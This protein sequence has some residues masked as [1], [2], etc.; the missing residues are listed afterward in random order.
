MRARLRVVGTV[1]GQAEHDGEPWLV[2]EYVPAPN[3]ADLAAGGLAPRRVAGI[4]A[5]VAEALA[6]AHGAGV[7]HRDVTPRNILVGA[8]DH[9]TLTDFG[10]SKIEGEDTLGTGGLPFAGVAAYVAPEVANGVKGG[11]KADVFS[12]GATLHAAVEGRSPW[13]DGDLV[14]TLAAAMKGGAVGGGAGAGA[15][16]GVVAGGDRGSARRDRRCLV[17]RGP[18]LGSR[19]SAAHRGDRAGRPDRAG[20]DGPAAGSGVPGALGRLSERPSCSSGWK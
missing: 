15:A 11:S 17:R 9:V 2:M 6:Y 12:L 5:Q 14:Q 20:G 4:G 10:I 8:G 16:P 7:L 1:H 13:G 3:L 19:R 18:R